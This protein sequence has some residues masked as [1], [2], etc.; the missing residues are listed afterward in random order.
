MQIKMKA[1]S[2]TLYLVVA[3]VVILV[4]ALVVLTIFWRGVTPAIGIAEAKSICQTQ[5]VT[6][7]ATFGQ[8]PP[9]WHVQNMRVVEGEV[10]GDKS[11][12]Q[13][14]I[15]D[16]GSDCDCKEDTKVLTGCGQGTTNPPPRTS[17]A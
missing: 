3:A 14:M 6:A 12:S 1:M 9:T 13:I 16:T 17:I 4:T 8:L 5:A 2:H 15:E 7:C 10:A 11:C